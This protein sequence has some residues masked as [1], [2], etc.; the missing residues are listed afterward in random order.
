VS[1]GFV[2][3][4][5]GGATSSRAVAL[6][7][8]G[9][10]LGSGTS[11]GANPNAH[12]PDVAAGHVTEALAET[13]RGLDPARVRGGVLGLAGS[14]KLTDPAVA[15]VFEKGW[16]SLGLECPL[17]MVSDSEVAFASA[18]PA[19]A[20]TALVAGTGSIAARVERHRMT[21]TAGGFGWLLGD[22]GSAFWIGRQAVRAALAELQTGTLRGPLARSVVAEAF[23]QQA[24]GQQAGGEARQLFSRLIT[25]CNAQPPIHLARF[26]P[27]VSAAAG[28]Q[29]GDDHAG[30]DPV[31][32]R[33][34]DEAAD[35]LVT[36]AAAVR[37]PA[38]STPVVLIGALI[39]P[40][41]PLT[42]RLRER[43]AARGGGEVLL[44]GEQSAGAAG[45][46]WL[47]AVE[48]LGESAPRPA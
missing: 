27:L 21:T 44:A 30:P 20:G 9:T 26:A 33:I 43:L 17:W 18:T 3:G 22:E 45:A 6:G 31:A 2:L 48:V 8:D 24:G 16:R 10:R 5:D 13:L 11:G 7:L 14:S 23:G 42:E 40:G 46:A 1:G 41:G 19:P 37:E 39:G 34:L 25:A 15:E 32:A 12:P 4:L 38:E 28:E 29:A 47:A 36:M 35:A